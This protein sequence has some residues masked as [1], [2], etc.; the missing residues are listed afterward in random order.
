MALTVTLA[1][2]CAAV[3]GEEQSKPGLRE[4]V[5][6]LCYARKLQASADEIHLAKFYA[7]ALQN[8]SALDSTWL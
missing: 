8:S 6:F 5:W 3:K 2:C 7:V 4:E 1:W